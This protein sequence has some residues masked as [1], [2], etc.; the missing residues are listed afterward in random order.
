[1]RRTFVEFDAIALNRTFAPRLSKHTGERSQSADV[2]LGS[3]PDS[4]RWMSAL[5]LKA[6]VDS[7]LGSLSNRAALVNNL[8]SLLPY[9]GIRVVSAVGMTPPHDG[10]SR[11]R[12]P[13][14]SFA[15][16]D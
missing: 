2:R 1:M 11:V 9:A 14:V 16:G 5:P 7:K 13:T 8:F 10:R 3:S 4:V 15:A 12:P 6:D